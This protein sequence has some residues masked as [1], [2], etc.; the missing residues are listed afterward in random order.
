MLARVNDK[1]KHLRDKM[2]FHYERIPQERIDEFATTRQI[3]EDRTQKI[4]N[5]RFP[6]LAVAR[7]AYLGKEPSLSTNRKRDVLEVCKF[8]E[9]V[10]KLA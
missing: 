1:S 4:V 9:V 6:E 3:D 5:Q 8:S 10:E 2:K 7:E